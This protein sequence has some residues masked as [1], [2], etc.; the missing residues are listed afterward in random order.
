VFFKYIQATY[1]SSNRLVIAIKI[2]QVSSSIASRFAMKR[3]TGVTLILS[4]VL[5]VVFSPGAAL[6][7][8]H[9][10][11]KPAAVKAQTA[12]A[13]KSPSDPGGI[14]IVSVNQSFG[15]FSGRLVLNS[16]GCETRGECNVG[17]GGLKFTQIIDGKKKIWSVQPG[18]KTDGASIPK[19]AQG[20]IG[21]PYDGSYLAAAVIHDNFCAR[22][23]ESWKN[24][25]RL[26]YDML[27]SL[28]INDLKAKIM[29]AGVVA[30]AHKWVKVKK[31]QSCGQGCT[32]N[33]PAGNQ[34]NGDNF[35]RGPDNSPAAQTAF[36]A[37]EAKINAAPEL[38]LDDIDNEAQQLLPND[39]YIKL[40]D[41]A[42]VTPFEFGTTLETMPAA[43]KTKPNLLK[44]LLQT[45]TPD[46]TVQ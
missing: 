26:F 43:A 36:A 45:S 41:K 44:K 6:A 13:A 5:C 17:N 11:Q 1:C 24:T 23:T 29:Y 16:K 19:F 2:A 18:L 27:R 3:H 30:G 28:G 9:A 15:F 25:H 33:L 39:P 4:L 7:G 37:L 20:I 40:R 34:M 22:E 42:E 14:K 35:E 38:S 46:A 32:F 12:K 8:K 31:P 21:K 10:A